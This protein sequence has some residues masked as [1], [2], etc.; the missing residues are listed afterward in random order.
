MSALA[1]GYLV[2]FSAACLAATVLGT[3]IYTINH[4][5]PPSERR[6]PQQE[7]RRAA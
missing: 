5:D 1:S 4:L 6:E 2:A 3:F 7:H